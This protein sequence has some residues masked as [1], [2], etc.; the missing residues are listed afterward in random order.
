VSPKRR[1][2]RLQGWWTANLRAWAEGR[3]EAGPEWR[4]RIA[5]PGEVIRPLV[6]DVGYLSYERMGEATEDELEAPLMAPNVAVE[7]LSPGDKQRHVDHK[8]EVYLASGAD[9][10]IVVDPE[11][12]TVTVHDVDGVRVFNGTQTFAHPSLPG[13][14][15]RVDEM[16]DEL[17]LRRPG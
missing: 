3:G 13:F 14:T 11:A 15:F 17:R 4:F 5:P 9:A 12:W 7:I 16:F 10:V 6:P 2:S 8:I 1:H